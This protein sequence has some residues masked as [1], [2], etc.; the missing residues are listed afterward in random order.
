MQISGEIDTVNDQLFTGR[1]TLLLLNQQC[2]S[3]V[4][5]SAVTRF[6]GDK[7]TIRRVRYFTK[8]NILLV[9]LEFFYRTFRY[10]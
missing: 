7:K 5:F 4:N 2:P 3:T 10:G 6:V 8:L 1:M 9:L